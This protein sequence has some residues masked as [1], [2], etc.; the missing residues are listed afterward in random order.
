MQP[1]VFDTLYEFTP[2]RESAF[3]PW[4][5]GF[6]LNTYL[7]RTHGIVSVECRGAGHLK[8]SLADGHGI[9]LASNHCRPCDPMVLGVLSKQVGR[10]FFIMAS[11]HLFAAGGFQAWLL[12]RL[13]VFSVY[14][15]GMDREA[16]KTAIDI[17]RAARRP[18]VVFPE[19]VVSRTNDRLNHLQEGAAF[20]A[21]SAAK[22]RAAAQPPG[23]VVIHPVAIRYR[24]EGDLEA[25]VAPVL[26][27]IERRLA[28]TPKRDRSLFDR[29]ALVGRALLSLKEIEYFGQTQ[30]GTLA[31]RIQRLIDHLLDPLEK[32]WLSKR[33][34][35]GA[36]D[37]VARVKR[38]RLAILPDMV[39]GEISEA[40][41][42]RRWRQL[43]D[44][45][46]AQQLFFYPPDYIQDPPIPERLLETVE[47]FE[48]DL[49]DTA[50]AH[51]PIRVVV[52]VGEALEVPPGRERGHSP[53]PLLVTLHERLETLLAESRPVAKP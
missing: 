30:A 40:E 41:R 31:E 28:W 3:W 44:L 21:R 50:R 45:Y 37:V 29:V 9:L 15:E 16:L 22:H 7:D 46:L 51:R 39:V 24:F 48:E 18:L 43:A 53:D 10:P 36:S 38:L 1:V 25:S 13:G 4:L 5:L 12:P 33:D 6:W 27:D 20:L 23:K 35:I 32:E 47:R 11:A 26:D 14:R 49:T 52:Q 8:A 19:G 17:L 2:P 34:D 42:S